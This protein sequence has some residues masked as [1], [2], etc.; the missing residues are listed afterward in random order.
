MTPQHT[1]RAGETIRETISANDADMDALVI[2][3]VDNPGFV[4]IQDFAQLVGRATATLVIAPTAADVGSFTVTLR[5]EDTDGASDSET[6]GI[7]V[8]S[9]VHSVTVTPESATIAVDETVQLSAVTLDS[10]GDTLT[11]RAVS[12]TSSPTSVA[13][14]DAS[15]LVTGVAS[16]SATITATSCSRETCFPG[17]WV[18]RPPP[19][20]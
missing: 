1:I 19:A 7:T 16:G 10:G 2:R 14:V 15:G 11:G 6:C 17:G 13:T 3:V 5:V 9:A 4:S 8:I 20:C 12:W 18:L